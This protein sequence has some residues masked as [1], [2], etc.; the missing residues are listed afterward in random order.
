MDDVDMEDPETEYEAAEDPPESAAGT[1]AADVSE[2]E[3]PDILTTDLMN[4][5]S[6]KLNTK[7]R[8]LI[9][10]CLH[11]VDITKLTSH[12]AH[13]ASE[14]RSDTGD[15]LRRLVDELRGFG[16]Q[17]GL[18]DIA[19]SIV[20]RP[21][22]AGIPVH[23][24]YGCSSC[25]FHRKSRH[26]VVKHC[27]H[28]CSA[29]PNAYLMDCSV[30]RP[31]QNQGYI[32]VI[33]QETSSAI[34]PLVKA[35]VQLQADQIQKLRTEERNQ[36]LISPLL[37]RTGWHRHVAGHDIQ[38][39]IAAS[40]YPAA[41]EFPGLAKQVLEYFN[42]ATE[43]LPFTDLLV[44]QTLNTAE[45][46][47]TGINHEPLL[48][49]QEHDSSLAAYVRPVVNI[50]AILLRN[51]TGTYRIPLS[52]ELSAALDV[53]RD[54]FSAGSGVQLKDLHEAFFTLWV[55]EWGR[56]SAAQSLVDPTMA[57]LTLLALKKDGS[58]LEAQNLTGILAKLTRAIQLTAVYEIH[59]QMAA[60]GDQ[61]VGFQLAQAH[62][63]APYVQEAR[64]TTFASVR[65]LQHYAT[66]IAYSSI[67][68]PRIWWT[69]TKTWQALLYRGRKFTLDHL[70]AIV[71]RIQSNVISS[72]EYLTAGVDTDLCYDDLGDDPQN[73]DNGYTAADPMRP[74]IRDQ[75]ED[76]SARVLAAHGLLDRT[77]GKI[78]VLAARK[79]LSRFADLDHGQRRSPR[80]TELTA[81]MYRNTAERLR[82]L[83]MF[84]KR[85]CII[86]RY[87][88]TTSHHKQDKVIPNSLDAVT[89]DVIFRK[90]LF[91]DP[92]AAYLAPIV[93]PE[94]AAEV[95]QL[96]YTMLFVDFGRL[97]T[98][99]DL[100]KAMTAVAMGVC[101]WALTVADYR[102]IYIAYA[103][104]LLHQRD[105]DAEDAEEVDANQAGHSKPIG[106]AH[107]GLSQQT[108]V[109]A[110][111][112]TMRAFTDNSDV[113]CR[114]AHLCP[115]GK[116]LPYHQCTTNHY[117]E[118]H[119]SAEAAAPP[120]T[121]AGVVEL[122]SGA[123]RTF[124]AQI[125]SLVESQRVMQAMLNRLVAHPA[126]QQPAQ[127]NLPDH[128]PQSAQTASDDLAAQQVS[129]STTLVGAMSPATPAI[130]AERPPASGSSFHAPPPSF[131][132]GPSRHAQTAYSNEEDVFW[133]A[134][135]HSGPSG[136]PSVHSFSLPADSPSVRRPLTALNWRNPPRPRASSDVSMEGI[137]D[138]T[139]PS[140]PQELPGR[141]PRPM[142]QPLTA[143]P[144]LS[145][146]RTAIPAQHQ[147]STPMF[148]PVLF[149]PVPNGLEF[150]LDPPYDP[151]QPIT[152]DDMLLIVRKLLDRNTATWT[153]IEQRA[154]II[155][156][157]MLDRDIFISLRTAAGKSLIAI[158]PS[159]VELGITVI[160]I[161]L[162]ALLEDW[163]RRLTAMGVPF[164]AFEA[165]GKTVL[166]GRVQIVLVSVDVAS[167]HHWREAIQ[168]LLATGFVIVRIIVDEIHLAVTQNFRKCLQSVHELR[169]APCPLVLM[170][171]TIPPL[172]VPWFTEQFAVHNPLMI[173]GLSVRKEIAYD[174]RSPYKE[175]EHLVK[176]ILKDVRELLSQ[177]ED[178]YMIFVSS[179]GAGQKLAALLDLEVFHGLSADK[180]QDMTAQMQ[181]DIYNRWTSGQ[182][183]G[184]ITTNALS[185]GNDYAHVRYVAHV[186]TPPNAVDYIQE[187]GRAARDGRRALAAIFP[188]RSMPNWG[189]SQVIKDIS[190]SHVMEHIV[191]NMRSLSVKD[192][193][194]CIRYAL[195]TFND[196]IGKACYQLTDCERCIFCIERHKEP[197]KAREDAA[198]AID[199]MNVPLVQPLRPS[200][201]MPNVHTSAQVRDLLTARFGPAHE[202][203][204]DRTIER[205]GREA[206]ELGRYARFLTYAD[207]ACG[208]CLV[209]RL[210]GHPLAEKVHDF[211][212][213]PHACPTLRTKAE[214][215][216]FYTVRTNVHYSKKK[217]P[218]PCY[219]CHFP[220]MGNDTLHPEFTGSPLGGCGGY[221]SLDG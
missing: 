201:Y 23:A 196:G 59:G 119:S 80:G 41:D 195:G 146:S 53:M 100:S 49:L 143:V 40:A 83:Y 123:F 14:G 32:R 103:R 187:T 220:S 147:I 65:S 86:R 157:L 66:A 181:T 127:A 202:I 193:K 141:L 162:R 38:V 29:R 191:Y 25:V 189:Q 199:V 163:K 89:G 169:F 57:C 210:L 134:Q 47:R 24:T 84:G 207:E 203:A 8:V 78:D 87:N 82:N 221:G 69:D 188:Y 68:V 208:H 72:Y 161:P 128:P 102:H 176:P 99:D 111:E 74:A 61:T 20:P 108:F 172:S 88:K 153:C 184:I 22:I 12:F 212:H 106:R 62:A 73:R 133:G 34:A 159:R 131:P 76:V 145:S 75:F 174:L 142:S 144:T 149:F 50:L 112:D 140:L 71:A 182:K 156:L 117:A 200:Q 33:T 64:L 190:G 6:V 218:G 51:A 18:P 92:I 155:A 95:T 35:L 152:E 42:S 154:A 138:G 46:A 197:A 179:I 124:G 211:N 70:R 219:I 178:R 9:C 126:P 194:R 205:L 151:H 204:E 54:K 115:G 3:S 52:P 2:P 192:P 136:T 186:H 216:A 81:M 165:G 39:L 43:M 79:F 55:T 21:A 171:A 27:T 150:M 217:K 77:T 48:R 185:A 94:R 63:L 101:G 215:K 214:K 158:L 129:N 91:L 60:S 183:L 177:P 97:F 30:Q 45:P 166:S 122:F 170:S 11:M 109:G 132:A 13:H 98:T 7:L 114:N 28:H 116:G 67:N 58:F 105:E 10:H 107:Y 4:S 168:V 5:F 15:R 56:E 148:K 110:D 85:P 167:K 44:L 118:A 180:G 120:A 206:D 121:L 96:Y 175:V 209:Y 93:W 130:H 164:E 104:K 125:D 160:V 90:V 31:L 1:P 137:E 139:R 36:R 113:H 17:D 26:K 37:A 19:P 16:V 135:P 173:R 213:D 198:L